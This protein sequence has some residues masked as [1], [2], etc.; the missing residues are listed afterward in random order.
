MAGKLGQREP[1]GVR[2]QNVTDADD[3]LILS[4]KWSRTPNQGMVLPMSRMGLPIL[5]NPHRNSLL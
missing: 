3:Q 2:K 4:V 5:T 1:E